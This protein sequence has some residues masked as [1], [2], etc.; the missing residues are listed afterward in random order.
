MDVQQMTRLRTSFIVAG[1][2]LSFFGGAVLGATLAFKKAEA[3]YAEI[4]DA[5]IA[6]MKSYRLKAAKPSEDEEPILVAELAEKAVN[7]LETYRGTATPKDDE[8]SAEEFKMSTIRNVFQASLSDQDFNYELE[9][10]KRAEHPNEP[11]II[12]KDEYFENEP[13]NEQLHVTWFAGDEILADDQ[14]EPMIEGEETVGE[15]NLEKFG[16]GSG[17]NNVLYVRN[18]H[19]GADFEIIRSEGKYAH[20]VSG[21]IEHSDDYHRPKVRKF[22]ERD[23]D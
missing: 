14:D 22:R 10:A 19:L 17:D 21:F 4:A 9:I 16:Y 7:A 3:K 18:E 5:E 8:I 2:A 12:S 20:E 6:S 15:L 23:F 1:A 11:Y 13:D